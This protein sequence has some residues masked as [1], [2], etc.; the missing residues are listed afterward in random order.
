MAVVNV[1]PQWSRWSL[2][3][4]GGYYVGLKSFS[5]LMENPN[6]DPYL[7]LTHADI[8]KENDPWSASV[9]IRAIKV[10]APERGNS[11]L[12]WIVEVEYNSTGIASY[13]VTDDPLQE[14]PEIEYDGIVYEEEMDTDVDGKAIVNRAG[15][16]YRGIFG[17]KSDRILNYTRNEA[18]FNNP[19]AATYVGKVNKTAWL[20]A[21]PRSVKCNFIKAKQAWKNGIPYWVVAYQFQHRDPDWDV[22]P[23]NMGRRARYNRGGQFKVEAIKLEDGSQAT[24]PVLL[25]AGGFPVLNPDANDL[26]QARPDV[27]KRLKDAEFGDLNIT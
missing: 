4:Q 1:K 2:E 13:T 22:R 8:P 21:L 15:D 25:T 24:D 11:P 27:F 26:L 17:E 19:I 20:G 23:M 3:R 14:P 6:D 18:V 16:P 12:I 5:V 7:A 10:K 9:P